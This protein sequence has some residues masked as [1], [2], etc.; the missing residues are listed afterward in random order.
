VKTVYTPVDKKI[1][2]DAAAQPSGGFPSDEP[3]WNVSGGTDERE[4]TIDK[5]LC[6]VKFKKPGTYTVKAHCGDDDDGEE[7]EVVVVKVDVA[8]IAFN[9]NPT[10]HNNDALNIRKNNSTAISVP[11]YVKGGQNEP[12]AYIKDKS[13]SLLVQLEVE[14]E[15]INSLDIK[16]SSGGGESL[17][18]LDE[19]TVNFSNGV[20]N[21]GSDDPYTST[22]MDES[23]FA[24]FTVNG[25]TPDKV[26]N[27]EEKWIWKLTE[28]TCNGNTITVD[29]LEVEV[30]SGHK[31]Y[32]V[33][34]EPERPW[35]TAPGGGSNPW[36]GNQ[37]N[38]WSEVLVY[39]C[40]W[41]EGT[42]DEA[43]A[44]TPITENA[45]SNFGKEYKGRYTY[46]SH[47]DCDLTALLADDWAD[48]RDM[49]AVVQLFTQILGGST[50]KV[51][52][53]WDINTKPIL[54][55][56]KSSWNTYPWTFH[57]FGWYSGKVY[58]ACVKLNKSDPYIPCG[59]QLNG[60][61]KNDIYQS[62]AWNEQSSHSITSFE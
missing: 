50:V 29:P 54:R 56:G 15:S 45:Y 2:F 33:F 60:K 11:E 61:Y 43:A 28:I 27:S 7:M 51:K 58:D 20:S 8:K 6:Y 57:Q 21:E 3:D 42:S 52:R 44:I 37:D 59:K 25:T 30:T 39:A 41:A 49:S 48:C 34:G 38:P 9:Y 53:V 13:V 16:A 36:T 14:P 24:E 32:T 46:T 18:D 17:G 26:F 23:K 35:S 5:A 62:G 1:R 47:G 12:A 40:N 10:A 4:T 19:K 55:I 31:V 22:P